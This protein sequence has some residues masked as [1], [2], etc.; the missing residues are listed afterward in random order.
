[1]WGEMVGG[2]D[3]S[4]GKMVVHRRRVRGRVR[5]RVWERRLLGGGMRV[6]EMVVRMIDDDLMEIPPVY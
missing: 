3:E 2:G 6:G 1:M 4:E 5:G